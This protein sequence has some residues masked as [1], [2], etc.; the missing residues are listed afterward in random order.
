MLKDDPKKLIARHDALVHSEQRKVASHVQREAGEWILN[1]VLLEG[2]DVPF[3]YKR[4]RKYK[5]LVGASVNLTY[6]PSVENVADFEV[7]VMKV[8]R[9]RRA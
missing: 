6:Y 5:S 7:E 3:R 8:V 9:I 2:Q 4:K 1:T